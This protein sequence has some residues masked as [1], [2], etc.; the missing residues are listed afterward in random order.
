MA[1][2]TILPPYKNPEFG[3]QMVEG[4]EREWNL[5]NGSSYVSH[6][7]I[8]LFLHYCIGVILKC[9]AYSFIASSRCFSIQQADLEASNGTSSALRK[10]VQQLMDQDNAC[11][12]TFRQAQVMLSWHY[13]P[14]SCIKNNGFGTVCRERRFESERLER[15]YFRASLDHKAMLQTADAIKTAVPWDQETR[16]TVWEDAGLDLDEGDTPP[17]WL[18]DDATREG[19]KAIQVFDRAREEIVRLCHEFRALALWLTEEWEAT[20]SC[21]YIPAEQLQEVVTLTWDYLLGRDLPW[22]EHLKGMEKELPGDLQ[23]VGFSPEEE[24]IDGT[25]IEELQ[26]EETEVDDYLVEFVLQ[27]RMEEDC[28]SWEDEIVF[29]IAEGGEMG[30]S[31]VELFWGSSFLA[32]TWINTSSC[33]AWV[34]T[35]SCHKEDSCWMEN[36]QLEYRINLSLSP[37]ATA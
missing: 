15:A 23:N 31:H 13:A 6:L 18:A 20:Q 10:G 11:A 7:G 19:I 17:A 33:S 24:E 30:S 32:A 2:P 26:P 36:E 37:V 12:R 4:C 25:T 9:L 1:L 28:E 3:T 16:P 35:W 8:C 14:S 29:E 27:S 5:L 22:P 34:N 21:S